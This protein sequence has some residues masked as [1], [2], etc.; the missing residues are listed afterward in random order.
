MAP[1]G[2]VVVHVWGS[3][4]DVFPLLEIGKELRG[5]GH[6]VTLVSNAVFESCARRLGFRFVAC[7]TPAGYRAFLRYGE[8]LFSDAGLATFFDEYV[9]PRVDLDVKQLLDHVGPD[10]LIVANSL[11]SWASLIVAE[12]TGARVVNVFLTPAYA[13]DI[14]SEVAWLERAAAPL[15][16]VRSAVGLAPAVDWL[17]F[18]TSARLHL[19]A[20]P[21]WFAP[22]SPDCPVALTRVGFL[23]ND[24]AESVSADPEALRFLEA[25][26][27]PILISGGSSRFIRPAFYA[28]AAAACA[29]SGHR[30]MIAAPEANLVPAALPGSV[31]AFP[32][33]PFA[34]IMPRIRAVIHHGGYGVSVRALVSGRP[35][36]ILASGADRPDNGRR[37]EQLGVARVLEESDWDPGR[38]QAA[39]D[40]LLAS[41]SV[42]ERCAHWANQLALGGRSSAQGA[43]DAML[44]ATS[45]P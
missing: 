45:A 43:V 41:G 11:T 26:E 6:A 24:E 19:A 2:D 1:A 14:A 7:D 38:V 20:W 36:L 9:V 42:R 22:I 13:S 3:A 25:G 16:A 31:V 15:D 27:P 18:L 30:G 33:L 4:G 10:T 37:L 34:D 21:A 17:A 23:C 28:T 32:P 39:L 29:G 35:Q 5:R 40:D 12:R 8:Q 44:A